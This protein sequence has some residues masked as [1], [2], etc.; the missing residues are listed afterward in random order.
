MKFQSLRARSVRFG[1]NTTNINECQAVCRVYRLLTIPTLYF[2]QLDYRRKLACYR[3]GLTMIDLLKELRTVFQFG[4]FRFIASPY[5]LTHCHSITELRAAR[6]HVWILSTEWKIF[7]TKRTNSCCWICF[8][9]LSLP[10]LLF[11]IGTFEK[12]VR[13]LDYLLNPIDPVRSR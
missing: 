8:R 3:L 1:N 13:H 11:T 6:T 12:T 10:G 5:G 4:I 2:E 7:I 9:V